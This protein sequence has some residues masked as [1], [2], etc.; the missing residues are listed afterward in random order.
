MKKVLAIIPSA[1]LYGKERS[2]IE[3]YD[4]L[5]NK[6]GYKVDVV[7]NQLADS[8]LRQSLQNHRTHYIV[9]PNRHAKHFR[10][11]VYMV[12]YILSNIVTAYI[13]FKL[14]P[15]VLFLCS[16]LT[17]YD[18]YPVFRLSKKRIVYRIGDEPAYKGLSFY[19]YNKYVW[20]KFVVPKVATIVSISKYIQNA[21]EAT[22]RRNKNDVL[23]YNYPPERRCVDVAEEVLYKKDINADVVF[24]YIG[25]IIKIKG[26]DLLVKAAIDILRLYPKTLFYIAGSISYD[27][28]FGD[29]L[30]QMLP[31]EFRDRIIFLNEISNIELFFSQIDVLCVPSV[32]QEPLGN[33][34]VEAKKYATPCIIFPSGGMPELIHHEKDGYLCKVQDERSLYEGLKYYIEHK[35]FI[36]QHSLA[37]KQS[38]GLL[39]IDRQSF[40]EKWSNVFNCLSQK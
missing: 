4:Y 24:G 3:V 15:D 8:R 2:N 33:V 29:E 13:I 28:K 22:G 6:L 19:K 36:P 16:E 37:S 30:L 21:V 38:I 18:L 12:Q 23:I 17:F 9:Y 20:Q 40:E 1:V 39:K 14:K 10:I 5:V 31:Q 32:K 7:V 34:L 27:K 35:E 26:V 25:Q 11:L